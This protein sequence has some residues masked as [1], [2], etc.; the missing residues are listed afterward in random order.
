ML[1]GSPARRWVLGPGLGWELQDLAR[2]TPYP[3]LLGWSNPWSK[4]CST[5]PISAHLC[6]PEDW[7]T[8][9]AHELY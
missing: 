6:D 8:L 3:V 1:E 4:G 2:L 5:A 7:Q 9:F